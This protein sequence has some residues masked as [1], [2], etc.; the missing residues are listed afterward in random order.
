[1]KRGASLRLAW[2]ALLGLTPCLSGCFEDISQGADARVDGASTD[3]GVD[4]GADLGGA[5]LGVDVGADLGGTDLG[6][7]AGQDVAP[8]DAGGLDAGGLDAGGFETG[9]EDVAAGDVGDAGV[10]VRDVGFDI[11]T[12]DVPLNT[13][14]VLLGA[15]R[16]S[17]VAISTDD[18]VM[19]SA[20]RGANSVS[21]YALVPGSFAQVARIE[22]VSTGSG[23]EPWSVALH[24]DN[25]TAFAVLRRDQQLVRI[26]NLRGGATLAMARASLGA[27]PTGLAI[28]PLGRTAFAA[29]F[30]E[31]TV[32]VVDTGTMRVSGTIDLNAVLAAS[33]MLGPSA[34]A[35]PG[36]SHPRAV[37][38]T[39]DGDT[40]E[41]DETLYVTEYFAQRRLT[42]TQTGNDRFD[43]S[44]Q[45]VV[46]R[47]PLATLV[48]EVVTLAPVTDMGF[49]DAN[50][51]V[52]GCYPNALSAL[53]IAS[54]RVYVVATCVSPRGPSGDAPTST[55]ADAGVDAGADAGP[56]DA[57][58]DVGD[59][60]DSGPP[61]LPPLPQAR[62]NLRTVQTPAIF[63]LD[64]AASPTVELPA[65]RVL[66]NAR[67]QALYDARR[68]PDT[69][70]RRM[71]LNPVDIAF[72]PI[73]NGSTATSLV[74]W[75]LSA[76]SDAL[77]RVRFNT[78]GTLA[79][80]GA[81]A[82]APLYVDLAGG[83]LPGRTPYG[84]ALS[85]LSANNA[86]VVYE[87]SRNLNVVRLDTQ[88]VVAGTE[89]AN[90]APGIAVQQVLDGRRLFVSGLNRWSLNGQGWLS[91]ESC[92]PDGLSDNVTWYTARGP[93]QTPSLEE[94][95][96]LSGRPK[97]LGWTATH[98]ELADQESEVRGLGGGVGAIVYRNDNG[99]TPPVISA[100]DRI[101]YDGTA[102]V[103]PQRATAERNDGLHGAVDAI[104]TSTGTGS[105]RASNTHW[106]LLSLYVRSIRSPR[107]PVGLNAS[108][109]TAGRMRFVE[110][111]CAACHGGPRWTLAERFYDPGAR[112]TAAVGGALVAQSWTRPAGFPADIVT[113]ASAAYR[114]NPT[115]PRNDQISCVLR[116]VGT[117]AVGAGVTP[118]GVLLAEVRSDMTTASQGQNG[119]SPPSLV[120]LNLSAPYF[121]GGNA[122]TLEE[123]LS[124]TFRVHHQAYA[125]TFL[126]GTDRAT[127]VRQLAAFLQSLDG[128]NDPIAVPS[129]VPG[130]TAFNPNL[131]AGYRAP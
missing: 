63:V 123:A 118:M 87:N 34:T 78:S 97:L 80:V 73:A 54:N 105:V 33:G 109:V 108:D 48:P 38:V 60:P 124:D 130:T 86:A 40:D 120:G 51:V 114:L 113:A 19:V 50:N 81:A 26:D 44:H 10:D 11:P 14:A 128:R 107:P 1:M 22:E 129:T 122:R 49:R 74:A 46:Y 3:L 82:P 52:A 77:F 21:V 111:Q 9:A 95:L 45:G 16:T 53:A 91:C 94:T 106:S 32:S 57:S 65:Q 115:D 75:V 90:A 119:F 72:S 66:L 89:V 126:S 125:R 13:N 88:V 29:N 17:A 112:V 4:V 55:G 31:G 84:L 15:S 20:N 59:V 23:S 7:D 79:E 76:G 102:A 2:A 42:V 37:L 67:F 62:Q 98:D 35:R 27:E 117:W 93:R 39:N 43:L 131:C 70:A 30:A 5:D 68:T 100:A 92:H 24:P 85:S 71:P 103:A 83:V 110:G 61:A 96:D 101:V 6:V 28:S 18:R 99:A 25:N 41:R 104:A 36:L 8:V 116:S 47:I 12:V 121:H 58:G 64:H 56:R 69:D 127:V